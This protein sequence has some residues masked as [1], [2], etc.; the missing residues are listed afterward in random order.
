MTSIGDTHSRPCWPS[1]SADPHTERLSLAPFGHDE[2]AALAASI[3]DG[4]PEA[5]RVQALLDRS[6]GNP[7]YV[8]ELVADGGGAEIP[9]PVRT[10]VTARAAHLTESTQSLLRVASLIGRRPTHSLLAALSALDAPSLTAA[11]REAVDAMFL[12]PEPDDR[13][14]FR[15][16][17]VR[18]ALYDDLLPAERTELHGRLAA[19]IEESPNG[20][21]AEAAFHWGLAHESGRALAAAVRAADTALDGLAFGEAASLLLRALELWPVVTDARAASPASRARPSSSGPPRRP[22]PPATRTRRPGLPDWPQPRSTWTPSPSL[23]RPRRPACLV[24]VRRG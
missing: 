8:E 18:E 2:V 14:A 19:L 3:L 15:H 9:M 20:N 16:E 13:Y 7:F 22:P 23:A 10:I 12:L 24:R 6:D 1:W 4:M 21:D 5:S 17:L 11:L